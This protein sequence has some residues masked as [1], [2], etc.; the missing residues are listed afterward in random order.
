MFC[1]PD[2]QTP[3]R[4]AAKYAK[5]WYAMAQE[6]CMFSVQ[7][8]LCRSPPPDANFLLGILQ[9]KPEIIDMLL[10]I[11]TLPRT[12]WYPESQVDSLAF[13]SLNQLMLFPI[14]GVPTLPLE[15]EGEHK[16]KYENESK[17]TV[18][19]IEILVSRPGWSS[20][21]IQ[22]WEKVENEPLSTITRYSFI[23]ISYRTRETHGS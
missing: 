12:P 20:H 21:L 3:P 14:R 19:S 2:Y 4:H 8:I 7:S 13:E 6:I 18:K 10:K 22:A 15:G 23:S 16:E 17:A 9:F 1:L 5:R 11:G